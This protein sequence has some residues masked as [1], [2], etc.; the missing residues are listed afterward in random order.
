MAQILVVS[1]ETGCGKT[2]QLPQFLLEK[3]MSC[4]READFNIICTQPC[5]VSTIFVAARISPERGESLGEAIGYQIRLE[6]KRSIETH[7]LLCTTGVLLQQLGFTYPVAEHSLEDVL[8]KT[9]YSMKSDFENFKGNSRRRRKQQDSKKDPLTEIAYPLVIVLVGV[10]DGSWEDMRKFDDRIP[11]RD[12]NNF[13]QRSA[14]LSSP[15][16]KHKV[17][18][19]RSQDRK[20]LSSKFTV[21]SYVQGNCIPQQLD[22]A[23]I[24]NYVKASS[25][26]TFFSS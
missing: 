12:Y 23:N 10:S 2:T 19:K 6:S 7:L 15:L 26:A 14:Q 25:S 11:T 4:L 5:R 22:K 21:L 24:I 17:A 16:Q 20:R 1:G 13:Q 3:E 9:R 18:P 8:E